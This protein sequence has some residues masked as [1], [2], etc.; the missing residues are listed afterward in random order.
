MSEAW[1][2]FGAVLPCSMAAVA[3][4]EFRDSAS[5]F[6][7]SCLNSARLGRTFLLRYPIKAPSV[8]L[9]SHGPWNF[10]RLSS[11]RPLRYS[12]KSRSSSKTDFRQASF[13]T[14][15][16]LFSFPLGIER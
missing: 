9:A 10:H 5:L 8:I 13:L 14:D 11:I 4:L 16:P 1:I 12:V 2:L 15:M 7:S 6:L 3:R